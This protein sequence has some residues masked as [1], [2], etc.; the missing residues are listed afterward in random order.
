[1]T[2]SRVEIYDSLDEVDALQDGWEDLWWRSDV[3]VP[4]VRVE[5]LKNWLASFAPGMPLRLIVV[6]QGE[7]WMAAIPLV[8]RHWGRVVP[9]G[10][11]PTNEWS[12][13][14]GMLL[15]REIDAE[16]LAGVAAALHEIGWPVIRL[17]LMRTDS[18]ALLSL[19]QALFDG[20]I[21]VECRPSYEV[22]Y[23]ETPGDWDAYQKTWSKNLRHRIGKCLR[24]LKEQ[25]NV[26]LNRMV[27]ASFDEALVPL[28]RALRIEDSGWKGRA[29]TSLLKAPGAA[30][31]LRRVAEL[32]IPRRELEIAFL[33]LDER[34]IAFEILI[35]AKDVLHSYKVG[36][37]EQYQSF[38]PGHLLMQELLH[39]AASTQ[40]VLGLRLLRP[41]QC[42]AQALA[43]SHVRA[44]P[45]DRLSAEM[46]PPGAA[47]RLPERPP[48]PCPR[49]RPSTR[50]LPGRARDR[51]ASH[52][53]P[54]RST[55]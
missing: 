11:L 35:H 15:D 17:P 49:N 4:T 12:G 46:V 31:Y 27:P 22:T 43:R 47:V 26:R 52:R 21:A 8:K 37:D 44:G 50:S 7:R 30:D 34:P 13:A 33:E 10:T 29:G 14:G 19:R 41:E 25:G 9:M 39:E 2:H 38:D 53:P 32:L 55:P 1:M 51:S 6:R 23:I 40:T 54:A 5:F 3:T 18:P 48:P 16:S 45:A 36:Y 42:G 24:R 28:E 20:G